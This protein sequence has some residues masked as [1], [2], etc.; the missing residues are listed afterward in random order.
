[1]LD[2]GLPKLDGLAVARRLR[3]D[4]GFQQAALIAMSGYAQAADR[5]ASAKAGF[6]AHLAKPVE[7][8]ELYRVI[9]EKRG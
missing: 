4:D 6:D 2:L 3:A 7:L 5:E 1:L 8:A 9:E